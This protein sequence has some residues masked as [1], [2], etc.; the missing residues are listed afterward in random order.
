MRTLS[1]RGICGPANQVVTCPKTQP[2]EVDRD[3]AETVA[4]GVAEGLRRAPLINVDVAPW[5]DPGFRGTQYPR[6]ARVVLSTF[7]ATNTRT[8]QL[9]RAM[10][11]YIGTTNAVI[12]TA[13]PVATGPV[14]VISFQCPD[15]YK[16]EEIV[17]S[18][19][20]HQILYLA[21]WTVSKNGRIELGPFY[22]YGGRA[23]MNVQAKRDD[24]IAVNIIMPT[25]DSFAVPCEVT[26]NG[27]IYPSINSTD[28]T[29]NK[30]LR[31]SPQ[32]SREEGMPG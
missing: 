20:D 2:P 28:G 10:A 22:L 11:G 5:I 1:L 24:T 32:W 25:G 27:Y 13:V 3:S 26:V 30:V 18:C 16:G 9:Q 12:A 14:S 23:R 7:G 8:V 15:N 31:V 6:T 29:Y 17:V 4:S 19:Q 21:Q